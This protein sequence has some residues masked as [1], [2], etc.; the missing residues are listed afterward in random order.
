MI[1]QSIELCCKEQNTFLLAPGGVCF[2]ISFSLS[3]SKCVCKIDDI[4]LC[5]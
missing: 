1:H 5:V 4:L 3:G 2:A